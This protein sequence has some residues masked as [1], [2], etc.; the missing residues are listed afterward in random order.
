MVAGIKCTTETR[1]FIKK[2]TKNWP[3]HNQT[4]TLNIYF[5]RLV[6]RMRPG[7]PLSSVCQPIRIMQGRLYTVRRTLPGA[8]WCSFHSRWASLSA[9]EL[10]I[11][12]CTDNDAA[13]T[14]CLPYVFPTCHVTRNCILAC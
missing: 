9:N 12:L 6:P 13:A 3:T 7:S 4:S 10:S 1:T 2:Q 5:I 8:Q 11:S 14:T